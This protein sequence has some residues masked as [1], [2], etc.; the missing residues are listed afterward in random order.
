[1]KDS[2][3]KCD[4]SCPMRRPWCACERYDD[5]HVAP[6]MGLQELT[7]ATA[8]LIPE[9]V[10]RAFAAAQKASIDLKKKRAH[11]VVAGPRRLRLPRE[12]APSR[13]P[14]PRC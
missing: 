3:P 9:A 10:Q 12:Q 4:G 6:P 13:S 1:M 7:D 5:G 8:E 14:M 2:G 11:K